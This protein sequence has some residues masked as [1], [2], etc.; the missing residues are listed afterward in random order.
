MGM[1][2][3]LDSN[4]YHVGHMEIGNVT[5]VALNKTRVF[6]PLHAFAN[7]VTH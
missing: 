6:H 7:I 2:A 3:A 5:A 1:G 4:M